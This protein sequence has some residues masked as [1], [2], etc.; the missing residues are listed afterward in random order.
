MLTLG[1]NTHRAGLVWSNP[2]DYKPLKLR[3]RSSSL[4]W[5]PAYE[6]FLIACRLREVCRVL[7]VTPC[8]ELVTKL[9]E[10]WR[11]ET[12]NFHLI[13]GEVTIT[14]KDVEVL[15]GLPTRGLPVTARPDRRTLEALCQQWL[16]VEPP[17]T[18]ISGQIVRV[19]WVKGLFDRLPAEA[20]Q[21]FLPSTHGRSLRFLWAPHY[22]LNGMG[23]TYRCTSYHLLG[24]LATKKS[25][26]ATRTL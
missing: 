6:P 7:G 18:A 21:R 5:Y 17:T 10:R 20:P 19:S 25:S 13:Q 16:G 26:F 24:T 11:P 1:E 15:T 2:A 23:T 14:L 22:W 9:I 8:R 12:N 4:T 3:Q